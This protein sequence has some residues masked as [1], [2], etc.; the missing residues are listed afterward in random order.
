M[1][2]GKRE[3]SKLSSGVPAH[4]E[5]VLWRKVL[6][7]MSQFLRLV[8]FLILDMLR[9]LATTAVKQMLELF[10]TS[11]QAKPDEVRM[12]LC[13]EGTTRSQILHKMVT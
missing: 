1:T 9:R 11:F 10:R 5:I 8:D 6:Q 3:C 13:L 12:V 7:R 4:I 2:E